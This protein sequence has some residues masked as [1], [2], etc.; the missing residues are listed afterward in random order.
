M[1]Q[2]VYINATQPSQSTPA[3]GVACGALGTVLTSNGPDQ[4]PS[5]QAAAAPVIPIGA[6]PT[7][8]VGL[9]AVNGL[10]ATFLRSDG[11]PALDQGIAPTW[12]AIHNWT[13]ASTCAFTGPVNSASR[14]GLS[15]AAGA[16]PGMGMY[17]VSTNVLGFSSN[18]VLRMTLSST[19]LA[20]LSTP[21]QTTV[22]AAGGASALPATPTGYLQ[23]GINGTTQKIPY[24]TN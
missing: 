2:I 7:A 13:T 6:N 3:W 12:T 9:T 5:F 8:L 24:Y 18:S 15:A 14:F 22:G 4:V 1:A 10:A 11:A 16:A 19:G 17:G 21:T 23:V 20:L